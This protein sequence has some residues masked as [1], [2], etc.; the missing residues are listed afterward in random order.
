[1]KYLVK[2]ALSVCPVNFFIFIGTI[3]NKNIFL[4]D[5]V[6]LTKYSPV[7]NTLSVCPVDFFVFIGTINNKNIFYLDRVFLTKYLL[8]N[9]NINRIIT[10]REFYHSPIFDV[11][12]FNYKY[13][14]IQ[15]IL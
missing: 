6:F 14:N 2:N 1:M 8:C 10:Y 11:L 12:N 15:I 3:N 5:R 7:K 4:F 13:L 9:N